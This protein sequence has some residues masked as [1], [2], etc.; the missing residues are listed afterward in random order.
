MSV[1]SNGSAH[2]TAAEPR[3]MPELINAK[4]FAKI[5]S[6]SERTLYRLKSTGELPEAIVLG[7][8]VRWRLAE[9]REWIARGCPSQLL[10]K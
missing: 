10:R 1:N 3:F 9:V 6:V 7:G 4:E 5:L 8:N 2:E